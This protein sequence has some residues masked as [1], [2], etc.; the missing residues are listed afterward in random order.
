[1]IPIHLHKEHFKGPRSK[2]KPF[3]YG[4]CTII[5]ATCDD[6]F[7]LDIPPLLGMDL[8]INVKLLKNYLPLL[9][10]SP[11]VSQPF[12]LDAKHLAPSLIDSILG[13]HVRQTQES[14]IPLFWIV[15]VGQYLHQER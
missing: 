4:L 13:M 15:K 12:E 14:N 7:V 8:I 11:Y 10:K 3:Q 5:K 1:M 6:A 9:L 2:L